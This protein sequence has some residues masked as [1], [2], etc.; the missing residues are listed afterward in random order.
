T[1]ATDRYGS[2]HR[3]HSTSLSRDR[4]LHSGAQLRWACLGV[5]A[6][7][8]FTY[9]AVTSDDVSLRDCAAAFHE[10]TGKFSA[11]PADRIID[12]ELSGKLADFLG[13][14]RR[15]FR[16][17]ADNLKATP[18]EFFGQFDQMWNF[19]ATRPAP[20]RPY[21]HHHNF[22]R[23]ICELPRLTIKSG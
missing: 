1:D 11:G 17:Q 12:L 16:G 15:I 13:I 2:T 22:A 10:S 8:V 7:E 23:V 5:E 4:F 9:L 18:L 21:I 3:C 19:N 6:D 14:F 20:R